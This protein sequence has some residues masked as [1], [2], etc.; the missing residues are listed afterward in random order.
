MKSSLSSEGDEGQLVLVEEE[1]AQEV[2]KMEE[3]D[4]KKFI[5]EDYSTRRW[6]YK[7][8]IDELGV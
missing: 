4:K 7:L 6:C 2:Q 5:R 8:I 1:D 3:I